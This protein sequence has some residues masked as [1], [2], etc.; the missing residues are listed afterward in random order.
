MPHANDSC[1]VCSMSD[2]VIAQMAR[3]LEIPE[4]NLTNKPCWKRV[5]QARGNCPGVISPEG[6]I[7][8][9]RMRGEAFTV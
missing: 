9:C 7:E 8:L 1:I 4:A 2:F 6:W 5:C 3:D